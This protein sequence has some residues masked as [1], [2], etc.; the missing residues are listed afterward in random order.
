MKKKIKHKA[1]IIFNTDADKVFYGRDSC[2][3]I[4][5]DIIPIFEDEFLRFDKKIDFGLLSD[6]DLF[7]LFSRKMDEIYSK[8]RG[9]RFHIEKNIAGRYQLSV[10]VF[11]D[12]DG[13]TLYAIPISILPTIKKINK[14]FH[15]YL[16]QI[17]SIY[18]R[19]GVG[20]IYYG[21]FSDWEID[22]LYEQWEELS[23]ELKRELRLYKKY[24]N[25]YY[26]KLSIGSYD[27]TIADELLIKSHIPDDLLIQVKEWEEKTL[28]LNMIDWNLEDMCQAAREA[29]AEER[30]IDVDDLYNDGQPVEMDSVFRIVWFHSQE[31]TSQICQSLGEMQGNFGEIYPNT[32]K[33]C[34]TKEE[35][36]NVRKEHDEKYQS[37]PG[38]L[39]ESM[40]TG[41]DLF[42]RIYEYFN[43]KQEELW[44]EK[45]Q[46]SDQQ[47]SLQYT[48]EKAILD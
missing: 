35:F 6:I 13:D 5:K 43:G 42:D 25:M 34:S 4:M 26:N 7:R 8:Y 36:L 47:L 18:G 28:R 38:L 2:I 46:T 40:T 23:D 39:K 17:L 16:C 45:N 19:H 31:Y 33:K 20:I 15:D 29:D 14:P 3:Q 44:N 1:D 41:C 37:V 21:D 22:S 30:E 27:Q 32:I 11:D 24:S 9:G 10:R 12:Y 48:Q